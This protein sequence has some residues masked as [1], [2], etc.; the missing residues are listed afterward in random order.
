MRYL[1]L[2]LLLGCQLP[3][4]KPIPELPEGSTIPVRISS[5]TRDGFKCSGVEVHPEFALTAAHC[6]DEPLW[7]DDIPVQF[8]MVPRGSWDMAVLHVPGLKG[9]D[10]VWTDHKP[11]VGD[12]AIL[13]GW[14]CSRGHTEL[15]VKLGIV[16]SIDDRDLT[17]DAVVCPGDSGGPVFDEQGHL[18]GLIV[19]MVASNHHAVVQYLGE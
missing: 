10:V 13:I 12:S 2:V 15:A 6:A 16:E 17:Y 4:A 18:L 11:S 3:A 19:R 9:P 14:G 1:V 5:I 7:V 8:T